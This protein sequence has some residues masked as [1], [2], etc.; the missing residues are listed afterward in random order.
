MANNQPTDPE[1]IAAYQRALEAQGTP[2]DLAAKAAEVL[3]DAEQS[4]ER[5]SVMSQVWTNFTGRTQK[6]D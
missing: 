6:S 2:S 3:D 1:A 4:P 5:Q